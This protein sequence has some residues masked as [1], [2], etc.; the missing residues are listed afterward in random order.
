MKN[1]LYGINSRLKNGR[2]KITKPEEITTKLFKM[3]HRERVKKRNHSISELWDN[4]KWTSIHVIEVL[5][6]EKRDRNYYLKKNFQIGY[7]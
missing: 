3:R 7:A 6:R 4:F 1:T 5:E 2:K